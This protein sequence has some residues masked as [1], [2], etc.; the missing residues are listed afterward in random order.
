MI[1]SDPERGRFSITGCIAYSK[2]I[3]YYQDRF[4]KGGVA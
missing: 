1:K 4:G 2:K 3:C